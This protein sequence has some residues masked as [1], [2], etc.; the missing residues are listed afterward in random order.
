MTTA[1]LKAKGYAAQLSAET[2]LDMYWFMLLS[3]RLDERAW[4]LHRQGK[5]AFHV[6]AI[7]HEATQVAAAF[8]IQRGVD[9]VYPYYRDLAMVLALGVTPRDFM[10]SVYGKQ[11]ELSS[12][13]R[14]MP[15]HW[16]ARHLNIVTQSAVVASQ[17]P[18]AAG[19]AFA[20]QYRQKLGLVDPRDPSK[21][22]LALTCLGEGST[23]QGDWHEGMNWAGVH[24]LPFICLV[25]N[26][27]YAISVPFELQSA[28]PN[29]ADRAA[30]YGVPG[31]VVDGNDVLAVYDVMREAVLRAYNGDGPTL[32]EAKTYRPVPHSSDDD[33][34]SYRS[35]EEVEEWKRRD[36][37]LRYT[38]FLMA[39]G[40]LTQHT[41]AEYEDQA[42]Q[43]V[44]E[45]QREA[46][47]A[48]YPP[49]EAALSAVYAPL[50]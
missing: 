48:P 19:T 16:S 38:E 35:R 7:G 46:E 27:Q 10:F 22:R 31:V 17:V 15:S 47:A 3:R 40:L 14:Q 13:G 45:A 6:S 18:Q 43:V 42:R 23:S 49:A 50:E 33:D 9:F 1:D 25:Q 37:I 26:N 34:R 41:I 44:D 5:I 20:I 8:A 12:G 36:P 29:V 11:G 24:K 32:V 21:P 39:E 30:A 4:V 28:V 2:L